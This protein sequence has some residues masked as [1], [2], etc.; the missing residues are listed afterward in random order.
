MHMHES[1]PAE[2]KKKN[3]LRRVA[4]FFAAAAFLPST[5]FSNA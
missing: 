2:R 5:R 3:V 4:R 1:E